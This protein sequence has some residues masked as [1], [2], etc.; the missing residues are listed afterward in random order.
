MTT[1]LYQKLQLTPLFQGLTSDD[2]MQIIG[3]TKF[4]F[5]HAE[6]GSDITREGDPCRTLSIII[7]G[8]ATSTHHADD[9]GYSVQEHMPTPCIMQ[10]ECLFGLVQHYTRTFTAITPCDIVKIGKNDI[11]H[12]SDEFV[13]F[14]MNLINCISALAQKAARTQWHPTPDDDRGRVTAF[15]KN[16]CAIPTGHKTIR[17]KMTRLAQ[18][19]GLNRRAVSAV[20]NQMSDEGCL[21]FSRGIIDIPHIEKLIII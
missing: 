14:R 6:R 3:Q 18:E 1:D 19:T 17:I 10:P 5:A 16:H 12:M 21:H 15:L 4:E 11:M 2:L 20:L 13:I 9:H 7:G 8:Q